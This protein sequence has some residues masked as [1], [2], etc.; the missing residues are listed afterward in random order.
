MMPNRQPFRS[1]RSRASLLTSLLLGIALIAVVAY[2]QFALR[3]IL[4][5][6]GEARAGRVSAQLAAILGQP[7]PARLAEMQQLVADAAIHRVL[8]EPSPA[9]EAAAFERLR[10][11]VTNVNQHQT[12]ELWSTGGTRVMARRFPES[13]SNVPLADAPPSGS[14]MQPYRAVDGVVVSDTVVPV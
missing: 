9:A 14:G 10:R 3:R 8:R 6:T 12:L 5:E 7:I 11:V 2:T 4:I 1:I 13:G